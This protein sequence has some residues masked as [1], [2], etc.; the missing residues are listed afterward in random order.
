MSAPKYTKDQ[1]DVFKRR[2]V[3]LKGRG[4]S[5]SQIGTELG[6]ANSHAAYYYYAG[7]KG[8]TRKSRATGRPM[9]RPPGSKN[10]KRIVSVLGSPVQA[11]GT[12][13][14]PLIDANYIAGYIRGARINIQDVL[15]ILNETKGEE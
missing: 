13:H 1:R 4:L 11:N 14:F 8:S 10:K 3:E 7:L 12:S 9:G 2:A 15:N 6:I 5:L